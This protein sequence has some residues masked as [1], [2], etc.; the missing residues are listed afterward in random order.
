M[1]GFFATLL[2]AALVS[3]ATISS[4]QAATVLDQDSFAPPPSGPPVNGRIVS[5]FGTIPPGLTNAFVG[6]TITAGV[7]GQLLTIQLQGIAARQ[8]DT[9][10]GFTLFDGDLSTGGRA[11]GDVTGILPLGATTSV[12]MDVS[13]FGYNVRPGQVFSFSLGILSGPPSASGVVVIGNFAGAVP[14]SPPTILNFIDYAGGVRL[15]SNNGSRFVPQLNGD[16]GFRT[17]VDEALT[18]VPE[19]QSWAMMIFGFAAVG[20]AMR[21]R[22]AQQGLAA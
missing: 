8:P 17:F 11:I 6:Q 20:G 9:I 1:R 2:A 16:I 12:I 22:R 18:G 15:I 13:A 10:F 4:A 5:S 3:V 7:T 21:R 14:P 19:P